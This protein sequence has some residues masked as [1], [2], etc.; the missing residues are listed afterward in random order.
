M[1][2][3]RGI[4]FEIIV[5]DNNSTDESIDYLS[6]KFPEVL[7]IHNHANLGFAKACNKGLDVSAGEYVLF[8]NPDTLISETS[9]STCIE[10]FKTHPHAGAVGVKMIDGSGKFLKESK[11]AFPSPLTSLY[12]LFGLSS[13]F[14]T[15][16]KISRYHLGHLHKN[17]N[18]EVEVLAG[19]FMMIKRDVL[20]SVGSFDETFFMYGEDIDLSYRIQKSGFKNYYVADAEIIH[21]K[22]ESTRQGSMNYVQLFYAAMSIFAKKHYGGAKAGIFQLSIQIAIWIRAFIAALGK[23]IKWIGLPFIDAAIIMFS[24]WSV[25]EIWSNY[26]RNDINYPNTLLLIAFPFFTLIY[27]IVAFYGGLYS[28]YYYKGQLIKS[29]IIATLVL[30]AVYSLLPEQYRFSRAIILFGTLTASLLIGTV[31]WVLLQQRIIQHAPDKVHK[32]NILIAGTDEEHQELKTFFNES[33]SSRIIGRLAVNE[34]TTAGAIAPV[35]ELETAA[36]AVAAH[37]VIFCCG[38]ISYQQIISII[39]KIKLPV[40]FRFHASGSSSIVS[41][42]TSG[43]SGEII[44]AE[45]LY[46]LSQPHYRRLK[47]LVDFTFALLLLVTLPVHIIFVKQRL[48]FIRNCINVLTGSKTWVGYSVDEKHLPNIP[49]SVLTITGKSK[50]E[51]I[52]PRAANQK[53]I[54]YW[55]AQDYEPVQDVKIILRNYSNLGNL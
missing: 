55:Y 2:A 12:K 34:S 40:R 24:F 14:P 16:K 46:N 23:F 19:A 20:N 26:I 44:A 38:A 22:G 8:V 15:S 18:H 35:N 10:F 37:E 5:V 43:S 7:F 30:L 11:R 21:F 25:K 1:K 42:D 49:E 3:G 28:R 41:S 29:G 54:D 48:R 51:I 17:E 27:L 50:H 52:S 36:S 53:T 45:T 9:L 13:L 31:R 39:Q 33:L 4:N 47:R 32:P 6:P